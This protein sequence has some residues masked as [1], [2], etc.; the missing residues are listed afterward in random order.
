MNRADIIQSLIDRYHY[1]SY[2][3]IGVD[4]G[5]V[6]NKIKCD[7]KIGVD[8]DSNSVATHKMKSE[9]FFTALSFFC[10]TYDIFFIDGLHHSNQCYRD[11]LHAIHFLNDE[12][13][14][15]C[16]DMLPTS[17]F[18]QETPQTTQGEWTGDV[19][20]AWIRLRMFHPDLYMRVVDCDYGCGIITK[21]KQNLL[22]LKEEINYE[23]FQINAEKWMNII[24]EEEFKQ[25]YL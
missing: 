6:F 4:S 23:N 5:E 3:E 7:L 14:I 2:C 15:I 13:T 25:I 17:K 24:T 12:G 21:G 11:I 20:K 9:D 18:M 16:H 22:F 19:W 10:E 1:K 8:P